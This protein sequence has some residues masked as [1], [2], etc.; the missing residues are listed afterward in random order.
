MNLKAATRKKLNNRIADAVKGMK[1]AIPMADLSS[2]LATEGITMEECLL[3]GRE[4]KANI[5][6]YHGQETV[7]GWLCLTWYKHDTGR[8]DLTAYLS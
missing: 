5:D 2:I 8:Y 1:D 7:N 6:L 3:C 4:G